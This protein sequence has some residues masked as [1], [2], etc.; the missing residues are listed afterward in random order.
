MRKRKEKVSERSDGLGCERGRVSHLFTSL[1]L[2]L[3]ADDRRETT[4]ELKSEKSKP[5]LDIRRDERKISGRSS[6]DST[7]TRRGRPYLVL[8]IERSSSI[9]SN[10]E[11]SLRIVGIGDCRDKTRRSV[12]ERT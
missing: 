2:L 1:K 4:A 9:Q 6:A 11:Y 5:A 7:R 8:L 10:N 12:L 3:Q